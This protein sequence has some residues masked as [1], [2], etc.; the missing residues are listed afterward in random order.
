V[1][2]IPRQA[3]GAEELRSRPPSWWIP[4]LEAA[5]Q[6]LDVPFPKPNVFPWAVRYVLL[7]LGLGNA[8]FW[9]YK[10]RT[11]FAQIGDHAGAM[12]FGLARAWNWDGQGHLLMGFWVRFIHRAFV[13]HYVKLCPVSTDVREARREPEN[14]ASQIANLKHIG[15]AK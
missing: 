10:S 8:S 1:K 6:Q 15:H 2:R 5:E 3:D 7:A 14:G 4:D 11:K 12:L 9:A 13:M